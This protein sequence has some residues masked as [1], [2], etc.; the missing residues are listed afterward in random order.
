MSIISVKKEDLLDVLIKSKYYQEFK[1]ADDSVYVP[2]KYFIK[3]MKYYY[4]KDFVSCE[5][6]NIFNLNR[7]F[8]I[9]REKFR[10]F[11]FLNYCSLPEK[12]RIFF[13]SLNSFRFWGVKTLPTTFLSF[14]FDHLYIEDLNDFKDFF[15]NKFK[16]IIDMRVEMFGEKS[17][18]GLRSKFRTDSKYILRHYND[19][20]IKYIHNS[21]NQMEMKFFIEY[22]FP[23]KVKKCYL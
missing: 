1:E 6:S 15:Y 9:D 8:F 16:N 14:A 2:Q 20:F 22:K 7:L 21:N 4:P 3:H 12:K 19:I 18:L 10:S 11:P 5:Y 23:Y 13:K 17:I